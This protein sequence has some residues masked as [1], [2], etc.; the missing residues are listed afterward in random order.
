MSKL[1]PG[2]NGPILFIFIIKGP[3]SNFTCNF[4]YY[5]F[6]LIPI[7]VSGLGFVVS[8]ENYFLFFFFRM[9]NNSISCS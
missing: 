4:F 7:H 1:D 9:I 2:E 5:Y 8:L 3:T 6:E